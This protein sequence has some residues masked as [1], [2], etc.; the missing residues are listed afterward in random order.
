MTIYYWKLLIK[1]FNAY[2]LKKFIQVTFIF[3]IF[4]FNSCKDEEFLLGLNT[5]SSKDKTHLRIYETD[6]ILLN[7]VKA[8]PL[9]T[10]NLN[11]ALLGNIN[12][13]VFGLLKCDF[14]TE[15]SPENG[16]VFKD[17]ISIT[18]V[19]LNLYS[20]AFFGDTASQEISIKIYP[21][22][23]KLDD[24]LT[25]NSLIGK[26]YDVTKRLNYVTVPVN[27]DK[28][29]ISI[30]LP[31]EYFDTLTK[32]DSING[33]NDFINLF[34]GLYITTKTNPTNGILRR[35]TLNNGYTS[36]SI[37]GKI[38]STKD[39]V[40]YFL[41]DTSCNRLI[42]YN[43]Y[44]NEDINEHLKEDINIDYSYVH[45]LGGLNTIIS[46]PDLNWL[47]DSMPLVI[48]KASITIKA[49]PYIY[50]KQPFT[51][52]LV[53]QDTIGNLTVDY[54][55]NNYTYISNNRYTFSLTQELN[56]FLYQNDTIPFKYMLTP[57]VQELYFN[58]SGVKLL[59][60]SIQ[61]SI[62][63]HKLSN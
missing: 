9:E 8:S 55:S 1:P 61:L 63:Y 45:S 17:I 32:V 51:S 18:K 48:N 11:Y 34:K 41:V 54:N 25:Y 7:T 30:A 4:V 15:F 14:L 36:L 10:N 62:I 27:F 29:F 52:K 16:Y 56:N 58:P 44:Y 37:R 28:K 42:R 59:T 35:I 47:K 3:F 2:H 50:K 24:S 40:F 38:S 20:D 57:Q 60:D 46:I 21:L 22:I 39:T 12:D 19:T 5:Q 13:S 49:V 33:Y 23:K 6:S 53:I 26:Y 43:T 31:V